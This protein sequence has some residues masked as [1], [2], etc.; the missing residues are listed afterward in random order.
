MRVYR[1]LEALGILAFGSISLSA[2]ESDKGETLRGKLVVRSGEAPVMETV[3]GTTE[4]KLIGL[5]GDSP[6]RA[7][8]CTIRG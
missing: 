1:R 5:D 2:W 7:R 8:C 3:Q 4:H 6:T